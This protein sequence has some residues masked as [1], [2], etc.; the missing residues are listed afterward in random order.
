MLTV[1]TPPSAS[2][3][4]CASA[5]NAVAKAVHGPLGVRDDHV[6]PA[7]QFIEATKLLKVAVTAVHGSKP[8]VAFVVEPAQGD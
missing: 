4:A 2:A 6:G 3:N 1:A 8:G 5:T 7:R